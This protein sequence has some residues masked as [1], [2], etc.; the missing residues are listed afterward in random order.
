[1]SNVRIMGEAP[2][3]AMNEIDLMQKKWTKTHIQILSQNWSRW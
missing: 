2:S 3:R 1:M